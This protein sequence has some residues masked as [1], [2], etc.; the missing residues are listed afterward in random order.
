MSAGQ[1]Q[2]VAQV[3]DQQQARLNLVLVADAVDTYADS[4]F[5]ELPHFFICLAGRRNSER[6]FYVSSA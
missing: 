3:M 4:L 6:S 1:S 5:H 2:H